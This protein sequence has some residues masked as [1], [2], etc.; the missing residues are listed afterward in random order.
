MWF[1]CAYVLPIGNLVAEAPN[2]PFGLSFMGSL[3]GETDLIGLAYAYEQRTKHRDDVQ[4]YVVP[5]TE[6]W[7]VLGTE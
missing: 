3:F 2:V 4:P 1:L 5:K 6:I 7:D